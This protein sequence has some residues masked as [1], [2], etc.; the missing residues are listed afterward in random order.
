M[1]AAI[2]TQIRVPTIKSPRLRSLRLTSL[3]LTN[4]LSTFLPFSSSIQTLYPLFR[5][6][7][8]NS[9]A[10]L[11]SSVSDLIIQVVMGAPVYWTKRYDHHL[12]PARTL[13]YE[14]AC[15]GEKLDGARKCG[16][17]PSHRVDQSASMGTCKFASRLWLSVN[18]ALLTG[19][20]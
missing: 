4:C 8:N 6:S 20:P 3:S 16:P 19:R 1:I 2:T 17:S 11:G 5:W 7:S 12:A 13:F 18:H 9:S 10:R 14:I 15:T